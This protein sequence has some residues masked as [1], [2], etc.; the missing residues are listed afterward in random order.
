M[1][2]GKQCPG[3]QIAGLPC[4]L[5]TG[6]TK[7]TALLRVQIKGRAVVSAAAPAIYQLRQKAALAHGA[8][9]KHGLDDPEVCF[10]LAEHI[11]AV[12]QQPQLFFRFFSRWGKG[13]GHLSHIHG[14]TH[15]LNAGSDA[16]ENVFTFRFP[17]SVHIPARQQHKF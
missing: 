3:I 17:D 2:Q 6:G 14:K 10:F 1:P 9:L 11:K 16:V 15:S 5:C 13:C 4:F 8:Q 7:Q 12:E